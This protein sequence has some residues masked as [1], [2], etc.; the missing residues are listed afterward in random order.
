MVCAGIADAASPTALEEAFEAGY[1]AVSR[2]V[3]TDPAREGVATFMG[4][5]SPTSGAGRRLTEQTW[6]SRQVR[7]GPHRARR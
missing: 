1:E 7:E 4:S 2:E 6:L 5:G 3:T